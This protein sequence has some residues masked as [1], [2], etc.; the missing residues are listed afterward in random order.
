MSMTDLKVGLTGR[1]HNRG[2]F[3]PDK[4]YFRLSGTSIACRGHRVDSG[5]SWRLLSP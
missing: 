3:V 5:G 2:V 4:L 1:I